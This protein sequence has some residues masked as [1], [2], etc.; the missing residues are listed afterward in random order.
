MFEGALLEKL[1][2]T[3]HHYTR[4]DMVYEHASHT[5]LPEYTLSLLRDSEH[6]EV[7]D[8]KAAKNVCEYTDISFSSPDSNKRKRA[9]D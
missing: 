6:E 7:S 8:E 3:L 1:G 4:Y 9:E 5:E 2:W